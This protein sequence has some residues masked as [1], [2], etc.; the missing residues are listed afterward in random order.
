M[1][2]RD[3]ASQWQL[4]DL[5]MGGKWSAIVH[6]RFCFTKKKSYHEGHEE[7]EGKRQNFVSFVVNKKVKKW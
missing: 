6:F 3:N 7:H 1:G 5:K 2:D 4:I